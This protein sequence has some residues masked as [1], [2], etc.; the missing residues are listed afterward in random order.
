MSRH[1]Y[2][3]KFCKHNSGSQLTDIDGVGG[4]PE[5]PHR[6]SSESSLCFSTKVLSWKLSPLLFPALAAPLVSCVFSKDS[7]RCPFPVCTARRSLQQ[8]TALPWV[9]LRIWVEKTLQ[10]P[11][12]VP[13]TGWL[14]LFPFGCPLQFDWRQTPHCQGDAEKHQSLRDWSQAFSEIPNQPA[15]RLNAT[16]QMQVPSQSAWKPHSWDSSRT[17]IQEKKKNIFKVLGNG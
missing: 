4:H 11:T 17:G 6:G 5:R 1:S 8:A 2:F 9:S 12:P 14:L 15:W 7:H 3:K 13:V 16:E 10:G